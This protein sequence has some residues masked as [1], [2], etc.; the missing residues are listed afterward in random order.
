MT[1]FIFYFFRSAK[2]I[3]V[4]LFKYSVNSQIQVKN[5]A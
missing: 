2:L 4:R 3:P 5:A 1:V